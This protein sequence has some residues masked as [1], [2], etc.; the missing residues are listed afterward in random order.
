MNFADTPHA[1]GYCCWCARHQQYLMP[2]GSCTVCSE[3]K[4]YQEHLARQARI[5]RREA[6]K[7]LKN[8]HNIVAQIPQTA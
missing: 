5:D 8:G 2:D 6:K 4:D 1:T 7:N 3:A